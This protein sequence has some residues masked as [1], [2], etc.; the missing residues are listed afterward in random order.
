MSKYKHLI[1]TGTVYVANG[2]YGD[3]YR[4]MLSVSDGEGFKTKAE[5]KKF[6]ARLKRY[7]VN[8]R[9]ADKTKSKDIHIDCNEHESYK[10]YTHVSAGPSLSYTHIEM[11]TDDLAE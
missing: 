8:N 4:Y 5:A 10:D 2:W 11:T 9:I 1:L 6:A 3:R 7:I